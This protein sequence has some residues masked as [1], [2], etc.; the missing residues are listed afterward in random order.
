MKSRNAPGPDKISPEAMKTSAEV[1]V[2]IMLD[3]SSTS[4]TQKRLQQSGNLA[5]MAARQNL[6]PR[7]MGKD[8]T[9]TNHRFHHTEEMEMDWI[10]PAKPQPNIA[11]QVLDWNPQ[12][13]RRRERPQKNWRRT[14]DIE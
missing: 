13:I 9:K 1:T 6:Q 3:L 14:V 2:D 11:R 7:A 4:G 5:Y 8:R 12:G 10:H